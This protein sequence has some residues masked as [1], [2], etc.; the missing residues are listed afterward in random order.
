MFYFSIGILMVLLTYFFFNSFPKFAFAFY[1]LSYCFFA[2]G[3]GLMEAKDEKEFKRII[4]FFFL[5][6]V[7]MN[8]G[9]TFYL[10]GKQYNTAQFEGITFDDPW[11]LGK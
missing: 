8:A 6:L 5:I 1:H 4:L 11:I 7:L 9:P 10:L 2:F 3:F